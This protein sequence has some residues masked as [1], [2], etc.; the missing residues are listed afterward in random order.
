MGQEPSQSGLAAL[1]RGSSQIQLTSLRSVWV[2]ARSLR[3]HAERGSAGKRAGHWSY[4]SKRTDQWPAL[5][6]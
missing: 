4:N 5:L 3:S 6:R 1:G 2:S